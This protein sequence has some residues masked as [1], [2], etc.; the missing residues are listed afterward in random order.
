MAGKGF[1]E[2]AHRHPVGVL[3]AFCSLMLK[4][5]CEGLVFCRTQVAN[6]IVLCSVQVDRR[7]APTRKN[8]LMVRGEQIEDFILV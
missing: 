8:F 3:R 5:V 1:K 7:T 2:I 4:R 6:T